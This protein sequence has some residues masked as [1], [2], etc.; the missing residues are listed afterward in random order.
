MFV[1]RKNKIL[2][3]SVIVLGVVTRL[4]VIICCSGLKR[5]SLK[6]L[7]AAETNKEITVSYTT[8]SAPTAISNAA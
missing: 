2:F 7:T 4:L 1:F 5:D 6:F 3:A 8:V